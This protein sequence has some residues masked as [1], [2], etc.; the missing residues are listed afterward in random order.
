MKNILITGGSG[1]VGTRLTE[2]LISQGYLVAHLSRS[3]KSS[4]NQL[5]QTFQWDIENG[6]IDPL[7]FDFAHRNKRIKSGDIIV[8]EALGGGLTWGSTLLKW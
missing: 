3:A 8:L 1:L 6:Y 7:A 2:L 4:H 5:I